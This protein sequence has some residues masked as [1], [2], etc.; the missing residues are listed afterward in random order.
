MRPLTLAEADSGLDDDD[1]SGDI[2]ILCGVVIEVRSE[3]YSVH[4]R[5]YTIDVTVIAGGQVVGE[6]LGSVRGSVMM[7]VLHP[8]PNHWRFHC[9]AF[10]Y[11]SRSPRA[12]YV[13]A[14]P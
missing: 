1:V 14:S 8:R 13:L 10:L 9:G 12:S 6:F 3:Q 2:N 7:T 4:G 11:E 5:V